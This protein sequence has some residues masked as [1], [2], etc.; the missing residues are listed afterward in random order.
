MTVKKEIFFW[1]KTLGIPTRQFIKPYIKLTNSARI[2][3]K[4]SFGHGT[5]TIMYNNVELKRKILMQIKLLSEL[6]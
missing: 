1:S 5:C 2:N 3:H 4:G 6:K